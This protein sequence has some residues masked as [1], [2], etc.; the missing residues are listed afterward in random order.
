MGRKGL[1]HVAIAEDFISRKS[2]IKKK[3]ES[4]HKNKH[5]VSESCHLISLPKT[6]LVGNSAVL[7]D[8][9]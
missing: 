9:G 3:K 7:N 8:I 2:F 6:G 1:I 4:E 5:L